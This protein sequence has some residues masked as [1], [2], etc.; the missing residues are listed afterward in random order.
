VKPEEAKKRIEWLRSELKKH[1]HSY[2]VLAKPKISDFEF[3]SMLKDLE[4]LEKMFPQFSDPSSPT[5][6]VGSDV[7][8]G[9]TQ[10]AHRYPMLSLANTYSFDELDEFDSRVRKVIP[11]GV[12]YVCELKYDGTAISITYLNGFLSRAVTRGDGTRGDEVTANV[13][14]IRS[15][16]HNLSG[17]DFPS[18]FEIRGEI[19]M[20]HAVF[21]SIN[22]QREEQGE[23]PFANPRNAAAGTLKILDSKVVASRSLDCYLY[24]ILGDNLPFENHFQ[25]IQKAKEWGFK[26]PA[27]AKLCGSIEEV[28]KFITHWDTARKQLPYDTDGVVV[29][30]NSLKFQ[31]LLGFTAKTPRWAIAYKYKAEQA[32]TKL[33]S[34]DFQ[35]GRTGAITPVANLEPVQLAGTTVKRATL[36]N[37]DQI[38]M[39]NLHKGDT[40]LV[41]KGGEI[42]PKIIGVVKD[43]RAINSAEVEFISHCPECGTELIRPEGEAKHYCP[44]LYE[45]PPQLKGRIIHFIS[46]KAMDIDGLGEETVEL[47]FNQGLIKDYADLYNLTFEQLLPLE[48]FAKKSATNAINSIAKSKEIP[49]HRLIFAL[50]IRFVGETTAQKLAKHFGSIDSIRN[51]SFEQLMEVDEVGERIATSIIEFFASNTNRI[52]IEKLEKNGV[53]AFFEANLVVAQSDKLLG[54]NVVISGTF[55]QVSRD[56]AKLL[57]EKHGGKVLSSVTGNTTLIIAGENMGPAKLEKARKL[58]IKIVSEDEFLKLIQ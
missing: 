52:L 43:K 11:Q 18:D 29:K 50:G 14:T 36:H 49:L 16:P 28:K 6:R 57:V 54:E 22:T 48:R 37:S 30:V 32:E 5:A 39:L 21:D 45:C 19:F 26:V 55:T 33:L 12:E 20:P 8:E 58:D 56:E 42:I 1:N 9:F 51:A 3:D 10:V 47:L 7:S 31:Y 35:V 46:R 23:A 53:N 44:N 4:V 41:E 15:I 25:N 13:K 40:V 34:V 24:F 27:E 2:Y 38:V 17:T